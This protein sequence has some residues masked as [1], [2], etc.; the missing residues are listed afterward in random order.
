MRRK[1]GWRL[2]EIWTRRLMESSRLTLVTME[3]V[4][5][6]PGLEV[7]NDV[8]P[9]DGRISDVLAASDIFAFPG[10]IDSYGYAILEAMAAGL[11]VVA[12]RQGAVPELVEDGVTGLIVPPHDDDAFARAL[13][14]LVAE[15]ARARALGAAGRARLLE[16]FDARATTRDLIE[17][18]RDAAR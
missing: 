1:G 4:E 8:R 14:S 7:R 12:S 2:V 10:E 5:P 17:V 18:I 9:G 6:A 15:P 16:R 11:P 3:H 13:Q